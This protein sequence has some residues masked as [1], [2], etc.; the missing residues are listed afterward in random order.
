MPKS[1]GLENNEDRRCAVISGGQ[2]AISRLSGHTSV[3]FGEERFL[4]FTCQVLMAH[5]I[6][7]YFYRL[8][9]SNTFVW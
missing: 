5:E 3:I 7:P 1:Q 4:V 6:S 9:H 8:K 2:T